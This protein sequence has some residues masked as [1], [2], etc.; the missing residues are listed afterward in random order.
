MA[1][2]YQY[3]RSLWGTGGPNVLRVMVGDNQTIVKGDLIIVDS[4]NG[5][6]IVGGAAAGGIIGIATGAITTVTSTDTDVLDVLVATPESVFRIANYVGSTVDAAT[7]AM[8]WGVAKYDYKA[9]EIDFN[10]V[11]GGFM[12]PVAVSNGGYTDVVFSA[13]KLWNA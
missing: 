9:G 4:S 10:D 3:V 7:S 12:I 1:E 5:K 13:A 2:K 8:C 6:A 11:T